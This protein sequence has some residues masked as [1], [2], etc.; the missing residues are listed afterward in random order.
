M[1]TYEVKAW[2][3]GKITYK[4]VNAWT[5]A[6]AWNEILKLGHMPLEIKLVQLFPGYKY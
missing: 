3:N 6:E 5:S 4:L 2:I 1:S